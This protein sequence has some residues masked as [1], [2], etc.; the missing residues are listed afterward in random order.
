MF[1]DSYDF[2]RL[3]QSISHGDWNAAMMIVTRM[4]REAHDEGLSEIFD[5]NL[6]GLRG[7]ILSRDKVQAQDILAVITA[8][9]VKLIRDRQ[10]EEKI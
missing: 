8:K 7:C 6:S 3:G 4:Q 5:F 1:V 9:R 10:E 2:M